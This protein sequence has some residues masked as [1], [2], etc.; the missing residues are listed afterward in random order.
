MNSN[1][2]VSTFSCESRAHSCA[3]SKKGR[4]FMMEPVYCNDLTNH[5]IARNGSKEVKK[6]DTNEA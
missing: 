1:Q 5:I 6:G 3:S 4:T 2:N